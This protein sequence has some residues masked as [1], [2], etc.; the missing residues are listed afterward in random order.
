MNP[1]AACAVVGKAKAVKLV[2]SISVVIE[3]V[4]VFIARIVPYKPF[5]SVIPY[6]AAEP[7]TEGTTKET[8]CPTL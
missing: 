3:L 4:A 5:I 8:T 6:E 1:A 2:V 7:P